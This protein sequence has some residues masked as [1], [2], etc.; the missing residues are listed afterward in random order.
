MTGSL[1]SRSPTSSYQVYAAGVNTIQ[2]WRLN[3]ESRFEEEV[4]L[5]HQFSNQ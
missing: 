4:I 5:Q 3:D 2:S 1:R